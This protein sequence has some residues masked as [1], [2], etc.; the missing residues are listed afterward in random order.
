MC[1]PEIF[2]DN[3]INNN[4]NTYN[5]KYDAVN[6]NYRLRQRDVDILNN[7][8]FESN[9]CNNAYNL[10]MNYME[11]NIN[12]AGEE[13]RERV[14]RLYNLLIYMLEGK[15][16]SNN[17]FDNFNPDTLT[18][19]KDIR[20]CHVF[21]YA[22]NKASH[23]ISQLMSENMINSPLLSILNNYRQVWSRHSTPESRLQTKYIL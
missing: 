23:M 9:K 22:D 21:S 4:D 15:K 19:K 20:L 2:I 11:D 5:N 12:Y 17:L 13:R 16:N 18:Y 7:S 3:I 8:V 1:E 6:K 14:G 10:I